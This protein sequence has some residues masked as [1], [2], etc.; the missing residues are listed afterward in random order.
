MKKNWQ[1]TVLVK[2][3]ADDYRPIQYIMQG[4]GFCGLWFEL[5][6]YTFIPR[7]ET[8]VL[9]EYIIEKYKNKTTKI[10]DLGTGSGNIAVVLA[11]RLDTEVYAID[12]SAEA[13]ETAG[14]NAVRYGV[15]NR[16]K[17]F[18]TDWFSEIK[19]A[20]FDLIVG[21]PPY[22][23]AEEWYSIAPN[24]KDYEPK[25]ALWAGENGMDAYKVIISQSPQFLAPYGRLI[26]E[27]GWNQAKAVS[28]IFKE[29]GKFTDIEII[30]DKQGKDRVI[31]G[32]ASA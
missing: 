5:N 19:A 12:I 32:T 25:T 17:F 1:N 6:T 26:L 7:P 2:T 8:E 20:P 24:V 13:L 15:Q 27:I 4:T 3:K 11:K 10:L 18:N 14:R 28:A 29:A 30:K 21:N 23:S 31:T 16:I 9:V 22:I